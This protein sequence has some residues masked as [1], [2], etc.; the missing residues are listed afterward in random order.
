MNKAMAL[1]GIGI[2]VLVSMACPTVEAVQ[3]DRG[4]KQ[5]AGNSFAEVFQRATNLFLTLDEN[6]MQPVVKQ[7]FALEVARAFYATTSRNA[8]GSL[9][10]EIAEIN[11]DTEIEKW[12]AK[13]WEASGLDA[14]ATRTTMTFPLQDMIASRLLQKLEPGSR[15]VSTKS[16][17]VAKQLAENQYVGIG[18]RVRWVDGKAM[19]DEP[20]PGG[21]AYK[22]GS[23]P[24]DF[25]LE[26]DGKSMDGLDLGKVID[27]LRGLEGSEVTVVVQNKDDTEPRTLDMVRTVI[28]IPSVQG[29]QQQ[30]DGSW[31]FLSDRQ[32]DHAYMKVS[33]VVGSTSAELKEAARQ[34]I[35]QG[36]RSVILDLRYVT[37]GDLHHVNMI[38]DVLTNQ[39]RFGTLVTGTG[40]S[41]DLQTRTQSDFEGLTL[42]V[43]TP[44]D[45]V[46]GPIL[47]LLASLK[48]R[49][50]TMLIGQE[51]VSDLKCLGSF[52]L[53]GNDGAIGQLA[54]ARLV[55]PGIEKVR[56]SRSDLSGRQVEQVHDL[57]RFSPNQI[58]KA[59]QDPMTVG[60]DWLTDQSASEGS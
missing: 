57:V 4:E 35:D 47:A 55:P 30:D 29:V 31:K 13:H 21:A 51:L 9:R 28:P 43:L 59:R 23:I 2:L 12:L 3:V 36:V 6:A 10:H 7:Q 8:P 18:I 39:T 27:E 41:R 33:Q 1:A 24:G 42:A 32:T 19:I 5:G 58:L 37:N 40:A 46:S 26:V 38:A 16:N 52:D 56:S 54:Y 22:A 11:T 44:D 15:Y 60:A 14:F 20:F 49:P 25:I 34:V 45:R 17:R 53:P 50:D 48:Q